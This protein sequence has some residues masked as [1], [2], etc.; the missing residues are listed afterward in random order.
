[1]CYVNFGIIHHLIIIHLLY[2]L[3]KKFFNFLYPYAKE[4]TS[5]YSNIRVKTCEFVRLE[6]DRCNVIFLNCSEG[7]K[8][9]ERKVCDV[10]Y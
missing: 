10:W 7:Y 8:Q 2:F 4:S 1:M 9:V 6:K 5:F 3:K